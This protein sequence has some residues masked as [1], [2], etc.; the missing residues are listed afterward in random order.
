MARDSINSKP[1]A[2]VITLDGEIVEEAG[3]G[4]L[5]ARY[6]VADRIRRSLCVQ[7]PERAI[8]LLGCFGVRKSER[9]K[10]DH[11]S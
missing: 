1:D 4:G 2:F 11:G 5:I 6:D 7:Y 8:E 10:G 9:G 3:K